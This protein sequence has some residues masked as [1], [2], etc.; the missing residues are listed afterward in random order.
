M[1]FYDIIIK[2]NGKLVTSPAL[3]GGPSFSLGAGARQGS[4]QQSTYT[5]Y[6]NGQTLPGALNIEL[7]LAIGAMATPQKGGS[8][9][10]W[11]VS[12]AEI[13]QSQDLINAEVEVWGGMRKGL[14]LA[15]PAQSA[16]PLMIGRVNQAFGNWVGA[17]QNLT[18]IF[19]PDVGRANDPKNFVFNWRRNTSLVDAIKATMSAALP[20]SRAECFISPSLKYDYDQV[21][22]YG[23]LPQ[24]AQALYSLTNVQAFAGIK[25]VNGL[26]Y[27]G[28][29][30]F[31]K[32]IDNRTYVFYDNTVR[33]RN[34]KAAT[35]TA[36]TEI[37]FADL[38]GQPTWIGPNTI[39]FKTVMRADISIGDE[40]RLPKAVAAFGIQ[41]IASSPTQESGSAGFASRDKLTFA[42]T[43]NIQTIRH[44][45]NFRQAD[46]ASW[47]TVFTAVFNASYGKAPAD[48]LNTGVTTK[49]PMPVKINEQQ[50]VVVNPT[51]PNIP[52]SQQV[53]V[54]R[55]TPPAAGP[56]PGV[57]SPQTQ[58][59]PVSS[60]V[61]PS[62]GFV[63]RSS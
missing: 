2:K 33:L 49:N 11:G 52:S 7:D 8:I 32:S 46:A 58:A 35:G 34:G 27:G 51:P 47:V 45:G 59:G 4:T 43:F 26:P 5:S 18:L 55:A 1:R 13:S 22:V 21:G 25:T 57:Q 24:F 19:S 23:S 17:E 53:V 61:M 63:V 31:T 10:V 3:S 40:V 6:F 48:S 12:K 29:E 9:T 15:E 20:G 30:C 39:S 38:I 42:G 54:V 41:T 60:A 28:V 14:P 50:S 16:V 44:Y 37:A 36:I 56:V 62:M